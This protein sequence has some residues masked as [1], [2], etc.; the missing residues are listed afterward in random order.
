MFKYIGDDNSFICRERGKEIEASLR[1]VEIPERPAVGK[2]LE[3]EVT[4]A[5]DLS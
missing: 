5:C 3:I 2:R 1:K 4:E